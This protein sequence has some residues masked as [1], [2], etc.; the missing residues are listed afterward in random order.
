MNSCVYTNNA[1]PPPFVSQIGRGTDSF[2]YN[3]A[4]VVALEASAVQGLSRMKVDADA[5]CIFDDDSSSSPPAVAPR[6]RCRRS[7]GSVVPSINEDDNEEKDFAVETSPTPT[8]DKTIPLYEEGDDATIF[9]GH[10]LIRREVLEIFVESGEVAEE[11][12][13]NPTTSTVVK[14]RRGSSLSAKTSKPPPIKTSKS[15]SRYTGQVGFRCRFCK[16]IPSFKR[17]KMSSVFPQKLSGIYRANIRFQARHFGT[18]KFIPKELRE[19][20]EELKYGEGATRGSKD[21]WV[22]SAVRKGL[23]DSPNGIVFCSVVG[24]K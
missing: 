14:R 13:Y 12:E 18:C 17:T 7:I 4:F 3:N 9:A 21:S 2:I 5:L 24:G 11:D 10:N 19:R 16:H 8:T 15:T 22:D 6:L 1:T 23:R 20:Y